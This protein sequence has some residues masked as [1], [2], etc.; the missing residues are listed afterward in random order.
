MK[1]YVTSNEPVYSEEG[2]RIKWAG[3]YS[4]NLAD[5]LHSLGHKVVLIA[6]ADSY[7]VAQELPYPVRPMV[8]PFGGISY[9]HI[10][11]NFPVFA[12]HGISTQMYLQMLGVSADRYLMSQAWV[13]STAEL[14]FGKPDVVINTGASTWNY[15]TSAYPT[16]VVTHGNDLLNRFEGS[17]LEEIADVGLKRS[18]IT[19]ASNEMASM[20]YAPY[21]RKGG[22][23][24]KAALINGAIRFDKLPV[25]LAAVDQ[26]VRIDLLNRYYEELRGISS[27]DFWVVHSCEL[28]GAEGLAGLMRAAQEYE[29]SL[30]V[31]VGTII[32]GLDA[33][34]EARLKDMIA[35]MEIEGVR[36]IG[37]LQDET[38]LGRFVGE[39]HV[40]TF[41]SGRDGIGML[42]ADSSN[43]SALSFNGSVGDVASVSTK[44]DMVDVNSVNTLRLAKDLAV[45]NTELPS[46]L[47]TD[48]IENLNY[49]IR[50]AQNLGNVGKPM[51]FTS[52]VEELSRHYRRF[53]AQ[54][55]ATTSLL[56]GVVTGVGRFSSS[57]KPNN[58]RA[59][60]MISQHFG[61]DVFGFKFERLL[62]K[63]KGKGVRGAQLG[64]PLS[65]W[66]RNARL[67]KIKPD[68]RVMRE[69]EYLHK[70]MGTD[71]FSKA[72]RRF[73]RAVMTY[74]GMRANYL[75]K[76]ELGAIADPRVMANGIF[77]ELSRAAGVKFKVFNDVLLEVSKLPVSEVMGR[78]YKT[79]VKRKAPIVR[80]EMLRKGR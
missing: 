38:D 23:P 9:S 35:D 30:G 33:S 54:E 19:I 67:D 24:E 7:E 12:S 4:K 70:A 3:R 21:L 18:F 77:A 34:T 62:N 53:A 56:D 47:R 63:I 10:D 48:L 5:A 58:D 37:Q 64:T 41:P 6:P 32:I 79:P 17:E 46:V 45:R 27:Y 72:V 73:D 59:L 57:D 74:L 20:Q 66:D 55:I 75:H 8:I 29:T 61:L 50:I 52:E 65:A 68:T 25:R 15:I 39:A 22:Y 26:N 80:L 44:V 60:Q 43:R 71:Q 16:A 69:F 2:G 11:H 78:E 1:V 76:L 49:K 40:I 14:F 28:A 36:F 31:N 42:Y 13:M 51:T